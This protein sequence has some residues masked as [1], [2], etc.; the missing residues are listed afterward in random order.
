[1]S[2]SRAHVTRAH[3]RNFVSRTHVFIPFEVRKT[4]R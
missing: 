1:M 2:G 3:H 4:A